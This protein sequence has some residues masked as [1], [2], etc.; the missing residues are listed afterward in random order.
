MARC[1]PGQGAGRASPGQAVGLAHLGLTDPPGGGCLHIPY[2]RGQKPNPELTV[3]LR[4]LG[5]GSSLWVR[6]GHCSWGLF[7]GWWGLLFTQGFH[8]AA[9]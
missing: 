8:D 1:W 9:F 7:L 6:W 3:W 5:L 2:I 4:L